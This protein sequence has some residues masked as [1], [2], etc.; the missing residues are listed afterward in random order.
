MAS[1]LGMDGRRALVIGGGLGIGHAT[2]QLLAQA[3]VVKSIAQAGS[4]GLVLLRAS[5]NQSAVT[6]W[7]AVNAAAARIPRLPVRG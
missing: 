3:G 4:D 1:I 5:I 2:S 7:W 6:V